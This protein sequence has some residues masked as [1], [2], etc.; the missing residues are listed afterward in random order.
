MQPGCFSSSCTLLNWTFGSMGIRPGLSGVFMCFL[1]PVHV[2]SLSLFTTP[3]LV[4]SLPAWK[5]CY[6]YIDLLPFPSHLPLSL[7]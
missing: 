5:C 4:V 6:Q 1:A 7:L 2:P 3:A